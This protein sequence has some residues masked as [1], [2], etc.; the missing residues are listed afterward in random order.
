MKPAG[1]DAGCQGMLA[2][3]TGA[4]SG[5][6]LAALRA[7]AG[8]GMF[9]IGVGRSERRCR[10]AENAA[11]KDMNTDKVK[12][13]RADLASLRA[14]SDLA[15]AIGTVAA[16]ENEGTLDVLVHNAASV[17]DRYVETEDGIEMQFAVN[18]LAA[19]LL[20]RELLPLL[21]RSA[22]G[23]II[24]VSSASHR[25]SRID[26]EDVMLRANYGCLRAYKQSKFANILFASELNRRLA[27]K[28]RI[29][30]FAV[31][32]GLANTRI[33]EKHTGGLTKLFWK[34]WRRFGKTAENGA[35]TIVFLATSKALAEPH[36]VYWKDCMPCEPD[37][38]SQREE[39]AA[40]LWE[41]SDRLC[42]RAA[43]GSKEP[44]SKLRGI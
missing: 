29:R 38:D 2:V 34:I 24:T 16:T 10:D 26:R 20:A 9:V 8:R 3:V 32:P 4:T 31:D 33:G 14:V 39:D 12:Y 7:L 18:H 19:F 22:S 35:K 28:S 36:A 40:F 42:E 13:L 37:P 21:Q 27:P 30:A 5:I 23:R 41:L 1:D 6:G 15:R 11:R 44:R 43:R 17:M 25:H